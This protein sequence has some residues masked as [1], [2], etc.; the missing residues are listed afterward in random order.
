MMYITTHE[1]LPG[2]LVTMDLK[3]DNQVPLA[4]IYNMYMRI[5]S[6]Y[7]HINKEKQFADALAI[8]YIMSQSL[9]VEVGAV[10][11]W[12]DLIATTFCSSLPPLYILYKSDYY[13]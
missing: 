4:F 6:I 9:F 2:F 13:G 3:L 12:S 7:A 11:Q 5:K 10:P 8:G 1:Q